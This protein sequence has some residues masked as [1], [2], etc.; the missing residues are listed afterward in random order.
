M[1]GFQ[2]LGVLMR[3]HPPPSS[4]QAELDFYHGKVIRLFPVKLQ[5]LWE[6]QDVRPLWLSTT[7]PGVRSW[8]GVS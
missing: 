5:V 2:D 6:G 7:D 3:P 4:L 8:G 1:T